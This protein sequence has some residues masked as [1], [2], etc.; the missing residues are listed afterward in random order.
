MF[1]RLFGEKPNKIIIP[2]EP[3]IVLIKKLKTYPENTYMLKLKDQK[4][5]NDNKIESIKLKIKSVPQSVINETDDDGNTPLHL[6]TKERYTDLMKLII[7]TIN[8][9]YNNNKEY[10]KEYINV[11]INAHNNAE[12]KTPLDFTIIGDVINPYVE[13]AKLLIENG[14][15]PDSMPKH[16]INSF[17]ELVSMGLRDYFPIIP[18]GNITNNNLD[19]KYKENKE[20]HPKYVKLQKLLPPP[21]PSFKKAAKKVILIN[22]LKPPKKVTK[23]VIVQPPVIQEELK[24][25]IQEEIIRETDQKTNE[26]G[27]FKQTVKKII[28][29]QKFNKPVIQE[30]AIPESNKNNQNWKKFKKLNNIKNSLNSVPKKKVEEVIVPKKKLTNVKDDPDTNQKS[31]YLNY[32]KPNFGKKKNIIKELLAFKKYLLSLN[33]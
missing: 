4:L 29:Q 31:R 16:G 1:T 33:K 21:P 25:V 12:H 11:L 27:K 17:R 7:E 19:Q 6:V 9:Y 26:P 28:T 20:I 10:G 3:L 32:R 24:P 15:D 23:P 22:T 5:F 14:A 2:P 8:N 13:G 30:E 18:P